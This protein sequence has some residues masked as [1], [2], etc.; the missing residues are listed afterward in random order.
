W[1]EAHHAT[2]RCSGPS[3]TSPPSGL[4][5]GTVRRY[6]DMLLCASERVN[7][8]LPLLWPR[9]P[10]SGRRRETAVGRNT[11][12]G[13]ADK[14]ALRRLPN[15][16]QGALEA[17]RALGPQA[18][19]RALAGRRSVRAPRTPH[20]DRRRRDAVRILVRQPRDGRRGAR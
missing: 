3:A 19:E 16:V 2:S 1:E 4:S 18:R 6:G 13:G 8:N 10:P 12:F 15:L 17:V 20:G 9:A 5:P 7:G 11:H 14:A